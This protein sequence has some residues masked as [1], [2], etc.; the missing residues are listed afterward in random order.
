MENFRNVKLYEGAPVEIYV[1]PTHEAGEGG[2]TMQEIVLLEMFKDDKKVAEF[3]ITNADF[4]EILELTE[5]QKEFGRECGV[6]TVFI[7][8]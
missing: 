5:I 2:A 6:K 3:D 7:N 1:Y 8:T 4:K